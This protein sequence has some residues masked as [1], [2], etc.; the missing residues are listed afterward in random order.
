MDNTLF[1]STV[2]DR[3]IQYIN[4]IQTK[5]MLLEQFFY[6]HHAV[7]QLSIE[8]AYLS[9]SMEHPRQFYSFI[10]LRLSILPLDFQ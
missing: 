4:H 7:T 9:D 5:F 10:S 6:I 8:G 1:L 2:A 3:L